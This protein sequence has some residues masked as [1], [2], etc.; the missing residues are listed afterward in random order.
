MEINKTKLFES[1]KSLKFESCRKLSNL[2]DLKAG[3]LLCEILAYIKSKPFKGPP[4]EFLK[5]NLPVSL[6]PKAEFLDLKNSCE[7]AFFLIEN[8]PKTVPKLRLALSEFNEANTSYTH[9]S[10][11]GNHFK[12]NARCCTPEPKHIP[13]AIKWANSLGF[14]ED[15]IMQAQSGVLYSGLINLLEKKTAISGIFNPAKTRSAVKINTRKVF[16][17][18]I[19]EK[20]FVSEFMNEKEIWSG[21]QK[22]IIGLLQDIKMLYESIS[23]LQSKENCSPYTQVSNDIQNLLLELGIDQYKN[24]TPTEIGEIV[25]KAISKSY[26]VCIPG[27]LPST[28]ISNSRKNL[29]NGFKQLLNIDPEVCL[30][31]SSQLKAII[32]DENCLLGLLKDLV[33]K[34]YAPNT[35]ELDIIAWLRS[36]KLIH[37]EKSLSSLAPR[38]KTGI[39]IYDLASKLTGKSFE[40]QIPISTLQCVDNISK[41]LDILFDHGLISYNLKQNPDLIYKSDKKAL[42]SLLTVIKF[43]EELLTHDLTPREY[44]SIEPVYKSITPPPRINI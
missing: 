4:L 38:L 31:Y 25:L 13:E 22:Y 17:F 16:Q 2:E 33:S 29:L 1:L 5:N 40:Y 15:I 14:T 3:F 41:G 35:S 7:I 27:A 24:I 39:F 19:Q 26:K 10:Y 44:K 9:R 34:Q 6:R 28:S 32:N 42:K 12:Y 23:M 11:L 36:L 20:K 18:L 8:M 37:T 43:R 21:N 30:K